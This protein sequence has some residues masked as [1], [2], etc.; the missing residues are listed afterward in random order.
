MLEFSKSEV[1]ELI[2]N[3]VRE[4]IYL[5]VDKS[6]A[7]LLIINLMTSGDP[8]IPLFLLPRDSENWDRDLDIDKLED[9]QK[10]KIKDKGSIV[11]LYTGGKD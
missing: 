2:R 11:E 7:G 5:I 9:W 8:I 4:E 10:E 6:D 1:G 3:K